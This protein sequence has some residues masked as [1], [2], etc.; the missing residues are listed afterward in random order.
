MQWCAVG[1]AN[2]GEGSSRE[3]AAMEPRYRSGAVILARSFARIHETNLKK[4]GILPLTFY[5]PATY[6]EIGERD[7]ISLLDLAALAPDRPVQCRITKPGGST[8]GFSCTHTFSAE[9]IAWFAA[10]GALNLIRLNRAV[11][12]ES[13]QPGASTSASRRPR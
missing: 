13:G 3:H 8:V 1:D 7:R 4:Q 6:D 5:D 10:G 9:Q 11:N 12:R 2:Y